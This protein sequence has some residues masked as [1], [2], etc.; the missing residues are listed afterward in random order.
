M[1]EVANVRVAPRLIFSRQIILRT[2]ICSSLVLL[3]IDTVYKSW[4]GI[5]PLTRQQC[6]LYSS[7]PQWLFFIY[8]Y[9]IELFLLV[10]AGVFAGALIE[11]HFLKTKMFMP[12]HPLTAFVYASI[13]PLCS[14]SA[15]PLIDAMKK[16]VPLRSVITFVVAAPLLNPYI[17]MLSFTV[18]GIY[19]TALRICCSM[20]LAVS[21]GYIAEY[22]AKRLGISEFRIPDPCMLNGGC[23]LRKKD[24]FESTYTVVKKTLLFLVIAGIFGVG[25]EFLAPGKF[26]YHMNLNDNVLGK[27]IVILIGIPVY[28][29][30]GADVLFL[31][32]LITYGGLSLGTAIAF[33]LTSTS[34]CV[35][36]I[37]L[38][39]KFI[40]KKLTAVI[41]S[42]IAIITFLLGCAIELLPKTNTLITPMIR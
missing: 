16:K 36:S 40:G 4:N 7:L 12:Q 38:L 5:T 3:F 37:V 27:V 31:Q 30:N 1:I 41:I 17:I 35:T 2:L 9:F 15:L 11:K 19:Y 39:I 18:L 10:I 28:F 6:L 32:P 29:C 24:V 25:V 34:V 8:E 21:T 22:S 20:I 13:L 33:S 23:S 14:C 26:L 42:S